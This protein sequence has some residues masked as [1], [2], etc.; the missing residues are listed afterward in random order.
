MN[1]L[2]I[3]FPV[4]TINRELDFR[5]FLG[6]MCADKTKHVFIG[7][8]NTIDRLLKNMEGGIYLGKNIFKQ[9]FPSVDITYY[10][11]LKKENSNLYIWMKKEQSI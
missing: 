3:L 9:I 5:L 2:N 1:R 6:A 8:H 7:Q 4:E 11:N 10:V